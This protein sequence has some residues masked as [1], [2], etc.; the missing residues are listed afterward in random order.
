ML[1]DAVLDLTD[2]ALWRMNLPFSTKPDLEMLGCLCT[3][4]SGSYLILNIQIL[5]WISI[6][7]TWSEKLFCL[8]TQETA[9]GALGV[10]SCFSLITFSPSLSSLVCSHSFLGL[11]TRFSFHLRLRHLTSHVRTTRNISKRYLADQ[12]SQFFLRIRWKK[13]FKRYVHVILKI[14]IEHALVKC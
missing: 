1:A 2:T 4:S 14:K 8:T 10:S 7:G 11:T 9:G 5:F 12:L 6:K 3:V 13:K